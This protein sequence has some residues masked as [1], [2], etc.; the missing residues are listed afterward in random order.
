MD[1]GAVLSYDRMH[2]TRPTPRR[3]RRALYHTDR[4]GI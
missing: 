1:A 3:L 2:Y 4:P